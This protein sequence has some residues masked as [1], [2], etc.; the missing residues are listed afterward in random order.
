M[1]QRRPLLQYVMQQ[2]RLLA[3][4]WKRS[5]QLCCPQVALRKRPFSDGNQAPDCRQ[6]VLCLRQWRVGNSTILCVDWCLQRTVVSSQLS[7]DVDDTFANDRNT[8]LS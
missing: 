5:L 3:H 6:M 8:H 4:P 2:L 7:L 1:R